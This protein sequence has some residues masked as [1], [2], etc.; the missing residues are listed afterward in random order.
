MDIPGCGSA[1]EGIVETA[2]LR[3]DRQ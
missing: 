1:G 2:S 3:K